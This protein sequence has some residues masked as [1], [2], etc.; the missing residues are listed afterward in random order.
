[1]ISVVTWK[2]G[3]LFS[4][5]YVNKLRNMVARNLHVPHRF[6]CV[7][8]DTNGMDTR[9]ESAP[10]WPVDLVDA[11]CSIRMKQ[12]DR[13]VASVLGER[14]LTIDLD[15][16]IVGDITPIVTRTEPLVC[17][18]AQYCNLY[19]GGLHLQ[20][21]GVLQGL[22]DAY[23]KDPMGLHKAAKAWPGGSHDGSD[24]DMLNYYLAANNIVPP[25]WPAN[26]INDGYGSERRNYLKVRRTK[27]TRS[28]TCRQ[29]GWDA[30]DRLP[31][32]GGVWAARVSNPLAP[33]VCKCGGRYSTK[34]GRG[35]GF[36]VEFDPSTVLKTLPAGTRIVPIGHRDMSALENAVHPWIK[37]HWR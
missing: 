33:R 17:Y 4:V 9:I 22:W 27:T 30:T 18:L 19:G 28:W 34:V 21:A 35:P 32:A 16:V 13:A 2:W 31:E 37:E 7:T 23:S 12:F 20:T 36:E 10:L 11:H 8:D 29:C 5:D 15:V 3:D 1:M 26:L 14:F 24:Q 25:T 6:I